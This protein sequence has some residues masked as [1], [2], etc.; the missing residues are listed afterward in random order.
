MQQYLN[1]NI[2]LLLVDID[3]WSNPFVASRVIW[4]CFNLMWWELWTAVF[5]SCKTSGRLNNFLSMEIVIFMQFLWRREL[6]SQ[7]R[8]YCQAPVLVPVMVVVPVIILSK[9]SFQFPDQ[10]IWHLLSLKRDQRWLY[11]PNTPT[12][13]PPT[14]DRVQITVDFWVLMSPNSKKFYW[15]AF[16]QQ[17]MGIHHF[18][19]KIAHL[20]FSHDSDLTTSETSKHH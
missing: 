12:I 2:Q 10:D 9:V 16:Y 18:K 8:M 1:I 5:H 13:H 6:H 4:T 20:I 15:G 14:N 3:T 19:P 7:V 17:I 11:N